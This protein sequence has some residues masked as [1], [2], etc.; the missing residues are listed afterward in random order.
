MT[1]VLIVGGG[2]VGLFLG[3]LLLQHGRG[4][5]GPGKADRPECPHQGHRD[6]SAGARR[7]G[8]HRRCRG[9]GRAGASRIR[10]GF[11]VS[12]GRR[13]AHMPFAPVSDRYPF[14]LAVPQPVTEAGS[15]AAAP[16]AGRRRAAPRGRVTDMHDDGARVTLSVTDAGCRLTL[17]A[18]LRGGRR[19]RQFD[20]AVAAGRSPAPEKRVSGPL[21]DG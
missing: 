7:A 12:A 19:R 4:G 16:G 2:P 10:R 18:A 14:V 15:R 5:A 8:A 13:I 20:D 1:D 17:S 11:A 9:A 3:A 6:P 21:P